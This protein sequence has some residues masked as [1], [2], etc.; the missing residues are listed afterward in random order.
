[1][2]LKLSKAMDLAGYSAAVLSASGIAIVGTIYGN[3]CNSSGTEGTVT[4]IQ[5]R[6]AIYTTG[7][8]NGVGTPK[9]L[10]FRVDPDFIQVTGRALARQVSLTQI[11]LAPGQFDPVTGTQRL[12]S[13]TISFPGVPQIINLDTLELNTAPAFTGGP[14]GDFRYTGNLSPGPEGVWGAEAG[15]IYFEGLTD[16]IPGETVVTG[17][18]VFPQGLYLY[19]GTGTLN[20]LAFNNGWGW[21]DIYTTKLVGLLGGQPTPTAFPRV[22]TSS[23]GASL[24]AEPPIAGDSFSWYVGGYVAD[25]D[26]TL[27][28]PKGELFFHNS[29]LLNPGNPPTPGQVGRFYVRWTDFNPFNVASAAGVPTRQHGRIRLTSR[30]LLPLRPMFNIAGEDYMAYTSGPGSLT[31][32]PIRSRVVVTGHKEG[33]VVGGTVALKHAVGFYSRAVDVVITSAPAARAAPRTGNVVEFESFVGGDLGEPA[34]GQAVEFTL[35]RRSTEG[36]V[37]TISGGIGTTSTLAHPAVDTSSAG[38]A[39]LS[40]VADGVPLAL[41]TDYTV[42]AATGVITWV[43]SQVGKLVLATYNHRATDAQP[44]HGVCLAPVVES[45]ENGIARTT[46]QFPDDDSLVGT[47]DM[48]TSALA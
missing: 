5:S 12:Y 17:P 33:G 39:E 30:C 26:A 4:Y 3:F 42:V 45:D 23:P 25:P 48:L 15:A 37:V 47:I 36:E 11:H 29:Q 10:L 19:P 31:W 6:D 44:P 43:T 35:S 38:V 46:V 20:G 13:H 2:S 16:G 28:R 27:G 32:D 7:L 21:V 41:T 14:F 9:G 22:A 40:L 8:L 1:M 18:N 34:A 24:H